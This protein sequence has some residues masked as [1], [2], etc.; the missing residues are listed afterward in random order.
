M[1]SQKTSL[2]LILLAGFVVAGAPATALAG[3]AKPAPKIATVALACV[4]ADGSLKITND[5][6]RGWG[7][8]D[9]IDWKA[10]HLT[11]SFGAPVNWQ[12]GSSLVI[13]VGAAKK[14]IACSAWVPAPKKT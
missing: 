13:S 8:F 12:K 9:R 11:G 3:H 1:L 14:G 5:A 10:G 7:A 6:A 2:G 4:A